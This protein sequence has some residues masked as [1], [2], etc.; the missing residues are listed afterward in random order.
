MLFGIRGRSKSSTYGIVVDVGS[1][2]IGVAIIE[3]PYG[4]KRP[5]II[6]SKRTPVERKHKN[7]TAASVKCELQLAVQST[8]A[9]AAKHG[10]RALRA[11]DAKATIANV[12]VSIAAPWSY[13]V[14]KTIRVKHERPF[15]LTKDIIAGMTERARTEAHAEFERT[16]APALQG[17]AL[18]SN[19]TMNVYANGYEIREPIGK[20]VLEVS[21]EQLI[22]LADADLVQA[23]ED[24]VEK[25]FR[26]ATLHIH[27]F[28]RIYYAALCSMQ[29]HTRD[30]CLVDIT[31]E[32]TELGIV[33]N[34]ML[35]HVAHVPYGTSTIARLI[36]AAYHIPVPEGLSTLR[37]DALDTVEA[38]IPKMRQVTDEYDDAVREAFMRSSSTLSIPKT[39][40]LHTDRNTEGFFGRRF[41]EVATRSGRGE[42]TV[43]QVT[44]R[45][46][47]AGTNDDSSLLLGAYVLHASPY[48]CTW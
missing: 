38:N 7:P 16:N 24:A 10:L 13:T 25:N 21:T 19:T 45:F 41:A 2:S 20:K 47:E 30:A 36:A 1:G 23:V 35:V 5:T 3:S 42:T 27:S 15:A 39:I 12:Q 37:S 4:A 48:V 14:T 43:H 44:S 22:D 32:A 9:L 28:M 11:H 26:S 33:Q 34:G 40:F 17:L 29:V 8:L 6:W 18:L 46:M 31:D